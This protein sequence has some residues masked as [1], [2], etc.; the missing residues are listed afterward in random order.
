VTDD[1]HH[2]EQ[3]DQPALDFT[4]EKG[5]GRVRLGGGYTIYVGP[6][7]KY[8]IV[9]FSLGMFFIMV[10]WGLSLVLQ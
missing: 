1:K 4:I 5:S 6:Y 2:D 8:T 10:C 9:L 3:Q 7:L